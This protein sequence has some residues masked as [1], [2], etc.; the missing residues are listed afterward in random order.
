MNSSGHI[1][2]LRVKA[3]KMDEYVINMRLRGELTRF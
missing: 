1:A 2:A 3:D